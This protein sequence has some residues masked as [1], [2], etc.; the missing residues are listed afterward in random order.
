MGLADDIID[1]APDA[2]MAELIA[3]KASASRQAPEEHHQ[4]IEFQG[5]IKVLCDAIDTKG[6]APNRADEWQ[7]EPSNHRNANNHSK[8][9]PKP[10][11][12]Y[13]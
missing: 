3:R 8:C 10:T 1:R 6:M 12:M 9:Q 2:H 13:S 5:T 11:E 7:G 4:R